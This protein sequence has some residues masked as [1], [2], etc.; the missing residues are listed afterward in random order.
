MKMS[1]TPQKRNSGSGTALFSDRT[2]SRSRSI[3][4]TGGC[5]L[6]ASSSTVSIR[7]L[8]V[9][10]HVVAGHF[11]RSDTPE[12]KKRR[13]FASRQHRR[14]IESRSRCSF[15]LCPLSS[16]RF[17]AP[18]CCLTRV[19]F[20]LSLSSSLFS[21][22]LPSVLTL[23]S[24][25]FISCFSFFLFF[26]LLLFF[27]RFFSEDRF[28]ARLTRISESKAWISLLFPFLA[29]RGLTVAFFPFAAWYRR[30]RF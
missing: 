21:P 30:G 24:I 7:A 8:H 20:F 29:C 15:P 23:Y 1:M 13:R 19:S 16:P 25:R 10:R 17:F 14:R 6:H 26:L 22:L 11:C 18:C 27:W 2:R 28:T 9:I 4:T 5:F 3:G 12:W